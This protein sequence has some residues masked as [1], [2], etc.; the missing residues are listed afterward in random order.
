M[1]TATMRTDTAGAVGSRAWWFLDALVVERRMATSGT[2]LVLELTLPAGAAPPLHLHR[3]YDDSTY[4]LDGQMVVRTG[5][6]MLLAEAGHWMSAPRGVPHA[7]R[8]V[9][10]R[11][12]RILVVHDAESFLE[13]I[14]ELGEPAA[15][16]RLPAPGRGP[17]S[18]V[19]LAAFAEHDVTV[20]GPSLTA[21]AAKAFLVRRG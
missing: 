3:G 9:G 15:E 5:D 16:L 2:P 1:S 21:E 19:V 11:P 7:F 12:A 8:V 4:V 14:I 6:E 17:G 10:G 20:L 18:D 13:L